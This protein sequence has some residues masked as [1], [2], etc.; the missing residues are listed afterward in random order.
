MRCQS[1]ASGIATPAIAA[2]ETIA[3]AEYDSE[4]VAP[5]LTTDRGPP[6][7]KVLTKHR[8]PVEQ[9]VKQQRRPQPARPTKHP[10]PPMH[11]RKLAIME[12]AVLTSMALTC[13][14]KTHAAACA[15]ARTFARCTF[16][17]CGD[18]VSFTN[19]QQST[20]PKLRVKGLSI[21]LGHH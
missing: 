8:M 5:P 10:S 14:S 13:P 11:R 19:V 18:G 16:R 2:T 1:D 3:K 4:M 12:G 6:S 17:P 21:Q 7:A 15:A 20:T 9:L